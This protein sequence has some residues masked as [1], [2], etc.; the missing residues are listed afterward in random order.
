MIFFICCSFHDG[1]IFPHNNDV[2]ADTEPVAKQNVKW[3]EEK[4]KQFNT[5]IIIK[6]DAYM[7]LIIRK[8]FLSV[9][10]KGLFELSIGAN[11]KIKS[12]E[13]SIKQ[14]E[15]TSKVECGK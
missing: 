9:L 1:N 8:R 6:M 4:N 14:S 2:A 13:I 12:A 10:T 7:Q 15:H 5:A 3:F 11:R